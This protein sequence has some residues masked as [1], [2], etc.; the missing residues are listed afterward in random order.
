M[1]APTNLPTLDAE[2]Q[3]ARRLKMWR[4]RVFGATWL[5]YVGYYFCR[6]PFS[7]AKSRIGHE[8]ALDAEQLAWIGAAYL[9]AYTL[10]QFLSG[11]IGPRVGPRKMLLW[12]MAVSIASGVGFA[13]SSSFAAFAVLSIINGF[14]QA[15]GWSNAVG[16]MASWFHREERG[17]VM[18]VWSTCFQVG[19]VAAPALTAWVLQAAGFRWAFLAGSLVLAAVWV[20][21]L[22]HQAN[23]PEDKGFAAIVEADGSGGTSADGGPVVWSRATWI[24]VWLVGGAYFA[25]KFIRYALDSWAPFFLSRKFGLR[26]DEAGYVSTLFGICGIVGVV[27]TG[28]LSDKVFGGRRALVS[29]IMIVGVVFATVLIV[30]VGTQSVL[31]FALCLGLIGFTLYGPDALLTGAGAMDIGGGRGAVRAAGIIS[32]LG[33]AGSVVQ[34]L[35]IGKM[36]KDNAGDIRPVLGTLLASALLAAACV[37][38][39]LVRNRRGLSDV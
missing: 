6:K 39:I 13:A 21:V 5:C 3:T 34:E 7:V 27:A 38:A 11:G 12:G 9:I 37:G 26:D 8:L 4:Y 28:R 36:Y 25:M 33:S 2:P 17:T 24:T 16:T 22:F 10:G 23:R 31:A 32:G 18:G 15:T 20:V 30:G 1:T 19:N 29:F 14:A 35:V